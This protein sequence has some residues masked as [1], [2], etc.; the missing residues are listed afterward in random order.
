[1][2]APWMA[3]RATGVH[4]AGVS[5]S[6]QAMSMIERVPSQPLAASL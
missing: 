3:V 5:D 2:S 1:M 4:Y 6:L